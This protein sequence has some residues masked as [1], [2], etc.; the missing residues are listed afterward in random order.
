MKTRIFYRFHVFSIVFMYFLLFSCIS[1]CFHVLSI[2]NMSPL[3]YIN[4]KMT[5]LQENIQENIFIIISGSQSM[6]VILY[7]VYNCLSGRQYLPQ[8][9]HKYKVKRTKDILVIPKGSNTSHQIMNRGYFLS[10][11]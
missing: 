4:F 5:H 7:L 1:Q 11:V 9:R 3:C 8:R 6:N 10:V 2:I